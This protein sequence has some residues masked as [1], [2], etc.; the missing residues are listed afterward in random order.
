MEWAS[1]GLIWP[2]AYD[3]Y[4]RPCHTLSRR[5]KDSLFIHD[6]EVSELRVRRSW[7]RRSRS[8]WC[9]LALAAESMIYLLHMEGLLFRNQ[10]SWGT[11][12]KEQHYVDWLY[13][14]YILVIMG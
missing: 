11:A 12:G 4:D 10:K 13:I 3:I 6:D 1:L 7:N 5:A 9:V 2:N 14:G 8:S